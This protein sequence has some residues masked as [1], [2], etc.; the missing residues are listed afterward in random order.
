MILEPAAEGGTRVG[1]N[2]AFEN[3]EVGARMER[4]VVPA[5]E[6]LLDRLSAEVLRATA[7]EAAAAPGRRA[8]DGIP[9]GE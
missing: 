6:Q 2:Q 3:P 5:N 1:W 9:F 7:T 8:G 4:I